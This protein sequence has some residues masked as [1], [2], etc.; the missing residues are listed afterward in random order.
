MSTL[1]WSLAKENPWPGLAVASLNL[2]VAL[3][4]VGLSLLLGVTI[5]LLAGLHAFVDRKA[6]PIKRQARWRRVA[7]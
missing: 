2:I 7:S 1:L 5:S 6:A 3:A 4:L